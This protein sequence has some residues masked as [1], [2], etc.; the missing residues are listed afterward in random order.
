MKFNLGNYYCNECKEETMFLHVYEL[1]ANVIVEC[2]K[3][4]WLWWVSKEEYSKKTEGITDENIKAKKYKYSRNAAFSKKNNYF[5][6]PKVFNG[7]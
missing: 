6:K 7:Y 4:G 2:T 3:C 1:Y 5:R